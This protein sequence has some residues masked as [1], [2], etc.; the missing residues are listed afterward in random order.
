MGIIDQNGPME[1]FQRKG[2]KHRKELMGRGL[3]QGHILEK[4]KKRRKKG[5][6]WED[7]PFNFCLQFWG[8]GL[9]GFSLGGPPVEERKT[10]L[11]GGG[12]LAVE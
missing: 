2:K 6:S 8:W 4:I 9:G 12:G 11:Q 5:P 1:S 7:D 10:S 3:P